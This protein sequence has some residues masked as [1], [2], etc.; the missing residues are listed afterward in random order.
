MH[1]GRYFLWSTRLTTTDAEAINR[2]IASFTALEVWVELLQGYMY[3]GFN[4]SAIDDPE[5]TLA[6]YLNTMIMVAGGNGKSEYRSR[7]IS[8]PLKD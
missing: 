7:P 8:A 2:G 5:N 4:S 3:Y 6:W 1:E